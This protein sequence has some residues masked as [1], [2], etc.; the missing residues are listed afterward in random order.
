VLSADEIVADIYREK[1]ITKEW[2]LDKFGSSN[3]GMRRLEKWIHPLVKKR[4][5]GFLKN[6]RKNVVVEVPLLYEAGFDRFFDLTI[7]VFAPKTDRLKRVLKR[8]MSKKL[9][10]FLDQRQMPAFKKNQRADFVLVNLDKRQLK[11]QVKG[12]SRFLQSLRYL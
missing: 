1:K 7:S 4:V 9:F 3:A 11:K 10:E 2:I 5:L 6:S 12:L 8:G